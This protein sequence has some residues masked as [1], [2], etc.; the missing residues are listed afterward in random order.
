MACSSADT[1]DGVG[2]LYEKFRY[3]NSVVR[4]KISRTVILTQQPCTLPLPLEGGFYVCG[5]FEW[6]FTKRL[7][8]YSEEG[9]LSAHGHDFIMALTEAHSM[10]VTWSIADCHVGPTH[11]SFAVCA[12]VIHVQVSQ[13]HEPVGRGP[14]GMCASVRI[15]ARA[16]VFVCVC[17]CVCDCAC[18]GIDGK[19]VYAG[20]TLLQFVH[21]MAGVL[22]SIVGGVPNRS[23]K[24][25]SLD[26]PKV[27]IEVFLTSDPLGT[28]RCV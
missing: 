3:R 24:A 27:D 6:D 21:V 20:W 8:N 4:G 5:P 19:F 26:F 15:C 9:P 13:S 7:A 18:I 16:R 17:V 10:C 11:D 2:L 22:Y 1:G 14:R 28:I 23:P 25:G 12:C